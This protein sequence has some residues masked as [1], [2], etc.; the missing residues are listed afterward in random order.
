MEYLDIITKIKSEREIQRIFQNEMAGVLDIDERT[1]RNIEKGKSIL[2]LQ[3]FLLVCSKLNK[4]PEHFIG[5]NGYTN[6]NHGSQVG[7]IGNN[8]QLLHINTSNGSISP[9]TI[10]TVQVLISALTDKLKGFEQ[11]V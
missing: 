6:I 9:E 3:Q 4:T 7:N 2:D 5:T 8:G 10:E 11:S 1:Y